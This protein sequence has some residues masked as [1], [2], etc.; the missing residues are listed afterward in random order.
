MKSA[1]SIITTLF[2]I[3][4]IY[5]FL[6]PYNQVTGS[7]LPENTEEISEPQKKPK[8]PSETEYIKRTFPFY[9]ADP[10]AHLVALKQAQIMRAASNADNNVPAWEFAGPLNI[11]GRISDIEYDPVNTDIIYAGAATG[12]VFKSTNGGLNWFPVFDDQAVLPVGDIAVDPVN[13]SIVY[14]GTG[15]ANGGHNNFAGGGIYK[16]TN[17]GQTWQLSGLENT[18]S[19]G[20]IVIDPLNPLKIY[21]AAVGSYFGPN[22][23]RGVYKSEN[24]GSTWNRILFLNDSTGAIDISMDPINPNNLLAAMWQRTRYPNGGQLYGP[25][26]GI[27]KTTDGGATW[28]VL[29]PANGLPN[30]SSSNVGRIG[31]STSASS[32]NISYALYTNGSTYSGF[33]KTTN[34][35]LNWTNANPNGTLQNGFSTFSW[36]FGN[37]RV[38]PTDPNTVYVLDF[39]VNRTT[40]SG[41]AWS[42]LQSNNIHV[43]QHALAFKPGDPGRTIFGNDGGIYNSSNGGNSFTKVS[44]LPVTQFYEIGIDANNPQRL[45]GGTQDNGTNRT[46]TGSLTDWTTIYDGDGFYVIVDFTNPNIIYAESQNGGLGKSTNGGTSFSSATNG[47]PSG[48]KRNWSTPVVMDPNNNNILYYGT[49]KVYRTTNSATSWSAVSPDLTNGNQTRLGTVTSIDVAKTNSNIIIAGTDD[50][51]VWITTNNGSNWTKVSQTLPYRWVTRVVFDPQ[52]DNIAYVTYNGLKWKDPQPHVFRT[53]NRGQ[54]WQNISSNLPDAPVNAFAVDPL[55]PN[56]LFVGSDVGAYVSFNTGQNWQFL[57]SGLPMV[58]VYDFK[59]HPTAYYLV[60]GTHGRSMYK[61]D[62]TLVVGINSSGENIP[63]NFTLEQNYPNPF[64][65]VTTI[66]YTIPEKGNVSLNIY[67]VSGKL[68][69]SLLSSEQNPGSYSLVWNGTD[70]INS[71]VSSGIYFYTLNLDGNISKTKKMILIR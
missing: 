34:A 25:S 66:K 24:G 31:I 70:N 67:D 44:E 47:I 28:T 65:P 49:N 26:S 10:D 55:R 17:G 21:A 71:N 56:V 53:D 37:V 13:P 35:G 59:I 38:H 36:Y 32:P 33:F 5:Y 62:L 68:V 22:P 15:E 54:T 2:I 64:N 14:V 18:V 30:S 7:S 52:N 57:G 46:L 29:G 19:I 1:I 6:K 43:D 20:R 51:N 23:E 12:G 61:I 45:Y 63:E 58:S 4:A 27:H 39:S 60:A 9:T 3:T 41:V 8:L 40:N 16:T 42:E 69:R 48:E 11:G 50:A